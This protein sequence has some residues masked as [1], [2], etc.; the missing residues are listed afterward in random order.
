[1]P[2]PPSPKPSQ[3]ERSE[4]IAMSSILFPRTVRVVSPSGESQEIAVFRDKDTRTHFSSRFLKALASGKIQ[5]SL[6]GSAGDRK[7]K[8]DQ[9]VKHR[10]VARAVETTMRARQRSADEAKHRQY[11]LNVRREL[12]RPKDQRR[13]MGVQDEKL[14]KVLGDVTTER[15]RREAAKNRKA[16]REFVRKHG[17][18]FGKRGV[19]HSVELYPTWQRKGSE[20]GPWVIEHGS[21][22]LY[23]LTVP[24][25]KQFF[26]FASS[27]SSNDVSCTY[28]FVTRYLSSGE[29]LV[30]YDRLIEFLL[31]FTKKVARFHSAPP[32]VRQDLE[33]L[34]RDLDE[35]MGCSAK[36]VKLRMYVVSHAMDSQLVLSA[37]ASEVKQSD[38]QARWFVSHDVANDLGSDYEIS[39]AAFARRTGLEYRPNSCLATCVL[40]S[41]FKSDD[42]QLP[43]FVE[44]G[45]GRRS[46]NRLPKANREDIRHRFG[47]DSTELSYDLVKR[48]CGVAEANPHKDD[49]VVLSFQQLD[50][51]LALYK[52]PIVCV[53]AD[54][55]YVHDYMPP[56]YDKKRG[57]AKILCVSHH[58]HTRLLPCD[59]ANQNSQKFSGAKLAKL[60]ARTRTQTE[61]E[62]DQSQSRTTAEALAGACHFTFR[63]NFEC[64]LMCLVQGASTTAEEIADTIVDRTM[65]LEENRKMGENDP[66]HEE[67][68]AKKHKAP[69]KAKGFWRNAQQ[70]MKEQIYG[71]IHFVGNTTELLL[72][73]KDRYGAIAGNLQ[74]GKSQTISSFDIQ[75]G[76]V[77]M[78][79]GNFALD[80]IVLEQDEVKVQTHI[81]TKEHMVAFNVWYERLYRAI[82]RK[83]FM[84]RYSP[85]FL[86]VA[87]ELRCRPL[88]FG[89]KRGGKGQIVGSVDFYKSYTSLLARHMKAVPVFDSWSTFAEY[90]GHELQ[91][92]TLYVIKRAERKRYSADKTLVLDRSHAMYF[93]FVLKKV[94][95]L[96]PTLAYSVES[97][98]EPRE[99]AAA[100]FS[101]TVRDLYA[102]S[103]LD[104]A[105]KKFL[106]NAILGCTDKHKR[107][108]S[109]ATFYEDYDEAMANLDQSINRHNLPIVLSTY[110]RSEE[111]PDSAEMVDDEAFLEKIHDLVR[112]T[113]MSANSFG[114]TRKVDG[115]ESIEIANGMTKQL[116]ALSEIAKET[117]LNGGRKLSKDEKDWIQKICWEGWD[118][119]LEGSDT[120]DKR[121]ARH[122]RSAAADE[123]TAE[124]DVVEELNLECKFS[125][126]RSIYV[127]V[128]KKSTQVM[129]DGFV[130]LSLLK[131]QL[132]RLTLLQVWKRLE[133]SHD[134][135]PVGVK[136]DAIFVELTA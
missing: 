72:A 16:H 102:D 128:T 83:E 8:L 91:D 97:C 78:S 4:A 64:P 107:T 33:K 66:K 44:T 69:G 95:M 13:E 53:N 30:N 118:A 15:V 2:S 68:E 55:R 134:L 28:D 22:R 112:D 7:S 19:Y 99:V 92:W 113:E 61:A 50:N 17:A 18:V 136:T 20:N 35:L 101:A 36:L 105:S 71:R 3:Q 75:H 80:E 54:G 46:Q 34:I 24:V 104:V 48:A 96:L 21:P 37:R 103:T 111:W 98:C 100:D 94:R 43:K 77:K 122:G 29:A 41:M 129:D 59:K 133:K 63:K 67:A 10:R 86:E 93:G 39:P 79:V 114:A 123:S 26:R 1:M 45:A 42:S 73:L 49:R 5:T 126:M 6:H 40:F 135:T 31:A 57:L 85:G 23:R 106:V 115:E 47:V 51:F 116:E 9:V 32:A 127:C 76:K 81:L 11:H 82:F 84:S 117:K 120:S 52:Q 62:H 90:D 87:W 60:K 124:R 108:R 38:R 12:L 109:R 125:T 110:R 121:R 27:R 89:P 25:I 58:G 119:P 74:L 131:Y 56:D 14:R 88:C 132:Q 65:E 70:E 130:P